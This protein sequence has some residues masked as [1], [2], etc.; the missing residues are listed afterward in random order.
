MMSIADSG[1]GT[2]GSPVSRTLNLRAYIRNPANDTTYFTLNAFGSPTQIDYPIGPSV[3]A[4][5]DSH[6][7]ITQSVSSTGHTVRYVWTAGSLVQLDSIVDVTLNQK[8]RLGFEDTYNRPDT[9]VGD[10]TPQYFSY[11]DAS[12]TFTVKLGSHPGATYSYDTYGRITQ[13]TDAGGHVSKAY[14]AVSGLRNTDSTE[15]PGPRRTKFRSDRF[16]RTLATV[17]PDGRTDSLGYDTMGRVKTSTDGLGRTTTVAYNTVFLTSVTDAR[18]QVTSFSP[19]PHGIVQETRP[20]DGALKTAYDVSYNAVRTSNARGDTVRFT[21]DALGRVTS[22]I[23]SDADTTT[24]AY[25]SATPTTAGFVAVRN[26]EAVDTIWVNHKDQRDSAVTYLNGQRYIRRS[27][28]DARG[29]R[30]TDSVSSSHWSPA[31]LRRWHYTETGALDSL[32]TWSGVTGL[33]PSSNDEDLAANVTLPNGLTQSRVWGALHSAYDIGYNVTAVNSAFGAK[34]E[35]DLNGRLES[36]VRASLDSS[37]K[38]TYDAVGR[39]TK[40]RRY[41]VSSVTCT[42]HSAFGAGCQAAD[43]GLVDS[44][45]F[46]YDSVGNLMNGVDTLKIP[47]NRVRAANGFL[48]SYD[49]LG[50][51]TSKQGSGW[52]QTLVWNALGQLKSVTTNGTTTTYGYDG[53]GRRVRKTISGTATRYL[54][55]G[56]D[57][58]MELDASGDPKVEYAYWG[59]DAPHSMKIGSNTYYVIRDPVGGSVQGLVRSDSTIQARYGY[60]AYGNL[61]P[62][63]FDNVGNSIR[64]AG[65]EY[66]GETGFYFNRARYY[67]PSIARFISEDPIGLQGGVNYYGYANDDPINFADP[68]GLTTYVSCSHVL[69]LPGTTVNGILLEPPVY[70]LVCTISTNEAAPGSSSEPPNSG[71]P[72]Q[73][74]SGPRPLNQNEKNR[75]MRAILNLLRSKT[76][77]EVGLA[78]YRLFPDKYRVDEI[79]QTG[80]LTSTGEWSNGMILLTD[81]AFDPRAYGSAPDMRLLQEI[82]GHEAGHSFLRLTPAQSRV[83]NRLGIPGMRKMGIPLDTVQKVGLNCKGV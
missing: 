68:F 80:G 10:V 14:V 60:S 83:H 20:G 27:F 30:V 28:Y 23:T 53:L 43:S 37:R 56:D 48:F 51:L 19:T 57:L 25:L 50:N 65:R 81:Y 47:G 16:G 1:K 26:A 73:P 18:G 40:E 17:F 62:G 41:W 13:V 21:Y 9:I 39:L 7:R 29:N 4:Q 63:S 72:R 34:F 61:R 52:N 44:T 58:F 49:T 67:D 82:V 32:Y 77:R 15:V 24:L 79:R 69:V 74:S 55:D 31:K 12:R 36:R 76:C 54:Y 33:N 35:L 6:G 71:N 2:S 66:D 70:E 8:I 11:N 46:V 38:F 75:V 22:R 42:P 59:L 3:T 78:A 45:A 5:Y 64:F